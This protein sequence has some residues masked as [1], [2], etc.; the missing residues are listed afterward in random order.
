M[1]NFSVYD[2]VAIVLKMIGIKDKNEIKKI[3]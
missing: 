2:N 1:A 3:L